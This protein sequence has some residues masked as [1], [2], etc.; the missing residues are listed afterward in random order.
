MTKAGDA[1]GA[2]GGFDGQELAALR[3]ASAAV[4]RIV[5]RAWLGEDDAAEEVVARHATALREALLRDDRESAA[6][7][8]AESSLATSEVDEPPGLG[9]CFCLRGMA[10]PAG[11]GFAITLC[12]LAAWYGAEQ[13]LAASTCGEDLV[14]SGRTYTESVI[15]ATPIWARNTVLSF[16]AFKAIRRCAGFEGR[17]L[18]ETLLAAGASGEASRA[19]WVATVG[20]DTTGGGGPPQ[21]TWE[22]A[23]RALR[24]QPRQAIAVGAAKLLLWHWSQ[25]L[26]YVWVFTVYFC[27]LDPTQQALGTLVAVR[28]LLYLL[29]TLFATATCPVYLLLDLVTVWNEA[30][31]NLQ[32]GT[33]IAA[34]VLTPHNYVALCLANRFRGTKGTF[35]MLAAVQV[36]ADLASCF[37]LVEI[38]SDRGTVAAAAAPFD[39]PLALNLTGDSA[40]QTGRFTGS[41]NSSG[42]WT[43]SGDSLELKWDGWDDLLQQHRGSPIAL[44]FGYGI[45]ATGFVLFFGPAS[46]SSLIADARNQATGKCKR[47]VAGMAG[48]AMTVALVYVLLLVGL[49]VGGYCDSRLPGGACATCAGGFNGH[50]CCPV[51][52]DGASC[53]VT[54]DADGFANAYAI[55]GCFDT[56]HCGTFSKSDG[57][58]RNGAPVY[59]IDGRLEL[60]RS[61]SCRDPN[62]FIHRERSGSQWEVSEIDTG[63]NSPKTYLSSACSSIAGPSAPTAPAY[64]ADGWEEG[65]GDGNECRGTWDHYYCK[66]AIVVQASKPP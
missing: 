25:P 13:G 6:Q 59:R 28:E 17:G 10:I 15:A 43:L 33:R 27:E 38:L 8:P 12:A 65:Y 48:A 64:S 50:S 51:G 21:A 14:L 20:T 16:V 42:E 40:S 31:N 55:T 7:R 23:R 54:T 63:Q 30:E 39:V 41:S 32:R 34:Y 60:A 3:D 46:V 36:M 57:E 9:C 44:I 52:R 26:T 58:A 2:G 11:G 35:L 47:A 62:S 4:W 56:A 22:E 24:L 45:T 66:G 5:L 29:S 53:E 61:S 1:L 19:G 49:F 18:A 37:A